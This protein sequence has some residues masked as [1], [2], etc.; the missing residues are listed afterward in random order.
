MKRA[1]DTM[2]G[3]GGAGGRAP[4]R[5]ALQTIADRGAQTIGAR[6]AP[7]VLA[8]FDATVQ[9]ACRA[10]MPK[11][12][13]TAR[14]AL[15]EDIL[16]LVCGVRVALLWDYWHVDGVEDGGDSD[17]WSSAGSGTLQLSQVLSFLT[18][19]RQSQPD[20]A[21]LVAL[22]VGPS[23]FIV[24]S[25][26]LSRKLQQD[27]Q[28]ENLDVELVAVDAY[29][30]APRMCSADERRTVCT[31]LQELGAG[32]LEVMSSRP[33]AHSQTGPLVRLPCP[34]PATLMVAVHGW[35]LEYP[36]IYCHCAQIS[37][38]SADSA[39]T[40]EPR[41]EG[42]GA[43]T[44]L[45]GQ[46]LTVCVVTAT[47]AA[48]EHRVCSF[49]LSADGDAMDSLERPSVS[50][51]WQMMRARFAVAR[52]AAVWEKPTFRTHSQP[53]GTGVTL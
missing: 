20:A 7:M 19:L 26:A 28:S 52:C 9:A 38:P 47:R 13:S 41:R 10:H 22:C 25:D 12:G 27:V 24:C 15:V 50:A 34:Q 36:I 45:G 49:S 4:L 31:R 2:P 35:L 37:P 51:W 8:M 14:R 6:T 33:P 32:L 53:A 1:T 23:L 42:A 21:P 11:L 40:C 44:C 43:A 17:G 46:T 29:L 30:P 16:L 48:A 5:R 18:E 3:S 39:A